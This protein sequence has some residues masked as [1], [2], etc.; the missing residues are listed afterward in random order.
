MQDKTIVREFTSI[1]SYTMAEYLFWY[2]GLVL[3]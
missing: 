2:T 3:A 1:S